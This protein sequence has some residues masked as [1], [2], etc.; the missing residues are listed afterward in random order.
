MQPFIE[1][2]DYLILA[3]ISTIWS[4]KQLETRKYSLHSVKIMFRD[5]Q[6]TIYKLHIF[7]NT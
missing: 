2:M 5:H 7:L 4:L 6:W 1:W 3:Y